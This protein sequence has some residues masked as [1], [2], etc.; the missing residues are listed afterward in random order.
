MIPCANRMRSVRWLAVYGFLLGFAGAVTFL[1]PLFVEEELGLSTRIAG[2]AAGLIGFTAIFGRVGWARFAERR[3]S[4]TG[5]LAALAFNC[6][7][8]KGK[9]DNLDDELAAIQ[10]ALG[11]D[12]PLFGCYCAGEVGPV[13][14]VERQGNALS[15]G[16]G[17][18]VMFTLISKP[19]E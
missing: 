9:L 19:Q 2:L 16:S 14:P 18:H 3:G 7:G 8:R 15:G 5:P 1:V 17:W 4:F 6:A 11:R 10:K 12:V 13:D